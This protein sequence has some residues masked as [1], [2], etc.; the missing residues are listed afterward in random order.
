MAISDVSDPIVS[1][2]SSIVPSSPSSSAAIL[3]T[4]APPVGSIIPQPPSSS[5]LPQYFIY[6]IGGGGALLASA[7]FVISVICCAWCCRRRKRG[8]VRENTQNSRNARLELRQQGNGVTRNGTLCS[9]GET[10]IADVKETSTDWKRQHEKLFPPG[11]TGYED[12]AS[13]NGGAS[14]SFTFNGQE[15]SEEPPRYEQLEFMS[16]PIAS[17]K[18]TAKQDEEEPVKLDLQLAQPSSFT[19]EL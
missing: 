19:N 10:S 6:A 14:P 7:V 18:T 13:L 2:T 11:L 17:G 1:P 16:M 8:G 15:L 4:G 9:S 12:S 3:S 5:S